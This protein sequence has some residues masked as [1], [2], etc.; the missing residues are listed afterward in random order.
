MRFLIAGASGFLGSRLHDNL[1]T[2]G[3][4]VTRLVRRQAGPGEATW[5]PYAGTLDPAVLES[6]DVVVNLAGSPTLGNPHSEKWATDLLRSRVTTTR[7]LAEAIAASG[8]RPA[9]LAGN[10]I[11]YYGDHGAAELDETASSLG[12]A[13]LTEVTKQWQ[14]VT[15]AASDA[16]ARVCILR[17][18]PVLDRRSAPLKQQLLQFKA[19]LGGRLGSGTQ[20]FPIISAEDWVAAVTFLG[21]HDDVRGPVNLCCPRVPTNAEFTRALADLVHRPAFFAV[22]A[23]VLKPTAGRMAPELLGSVRAV[24][25]LL[26]DAGFRFAD[27]DVTAVLASATA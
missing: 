18:A 17:T 24:P 8:R 2:A 6:T 14:A 21:E 4:D 13:F 9:F 20:Y 15:T 26:L 5:D 1:V 3:H 11:S 10:G 23:A 22:P 7:V 16:G 27:H 19:G 25:Q 12:D